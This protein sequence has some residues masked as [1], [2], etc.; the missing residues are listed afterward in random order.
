MEQFRKTRKARHLQVILLHFKVNLHPNDFIE[1]T[2]IE[3]RL[4]S[5][6][7]TRFAL[8]NNLLKV[9]YNYKKLFWSSTSS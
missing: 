1:V 5:T 4:D 9:N 3:R 6:R 8:K 7:S 2:S